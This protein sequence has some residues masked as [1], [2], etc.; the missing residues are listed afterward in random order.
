[1]DLIKN[2]KALRQGLNY[3]HLS[4]YCSC[5]SDIDGVFIL[6]N[7]ITIILEV[8]KDTPSHQPENLIHTVQF[9]M[10]RRLSE[11]NPDIY[12]VYATHNEEISDNPIDV[13]T[14]KPRYCERLGHQINV[15]GV[16]EDFGELVHWL[17]FKKPEYEYMIIADYSNTTGK[18]KGLGY[19]VN[20][21]SP[22]KWILDEYDSSKCR[23]MS[24]SEALTYIRQRYTQAF[25]KDVVYMIFKMNKTGRRYF[26]SQYVYEDFS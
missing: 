26:D 22:E 19:A 2:T 12:F 24:Q 21:P 7:G 20:M 23:F 18:H 17:S 16:F 15:E 1:M 4:R 25:N 8:K 9:N 6:Y 5:M 14:C 10:Y 13:I 3:S 11:Y